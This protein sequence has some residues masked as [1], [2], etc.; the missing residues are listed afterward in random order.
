MNRAWIVLTISVV[1]AFPAFG[2]GAPDGPDPKEF[3]KY[4]TVTVLSRLPLPEPE[5]GLVTQQLPMKPGFAAG[6]PIL[7]QGKKLYPL[8][9]LDVFLIIKGKPTQIM[10]EQADK[11]KLAVVVV[12]PIS[13]AR[14]ITGVDFTRINGLMFWEDTKTQWVPFEEYVKDNEVSPLNS[15][16]GWVSFEIYRWPIGDRMIGLY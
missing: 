9:N 11:M 1:L 7:V 14:R 5:F 2:S 12:I 3:G 16:P 6:V 10:A 8:L 13:Y 4:S 15:G